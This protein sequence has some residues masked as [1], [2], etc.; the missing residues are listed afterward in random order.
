MTIQNEEDLDLNEKI[1]TFGIEYIGR[2]SVAFRL[3]YSG[4]EIT[5]ENDFAILDALERT[6]EYWNEISKPIQS[7]EEFFYDFNLYRKLDDDGFIVYEVERKDKAKENLF[8]K[9]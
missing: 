8:K 2:G 4:F 3:H 1:S 6:E 7:P 9:V 5:T